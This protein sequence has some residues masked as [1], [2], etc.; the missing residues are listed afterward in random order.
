MAQIAIRGELNEVEN[1]N[2]TLRAELAPIWQ[3]ATKRDAVKALSNSLV[4]GRCKVRAYQLALKDMKQ[5]VRKYNKE[6]DK[7]KA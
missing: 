4:K 5:R 7:S 3:D 1:H 6:Y 2:K